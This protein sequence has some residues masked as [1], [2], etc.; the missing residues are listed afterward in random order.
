M[1]SF[2]KLC[3]IVF[4]IY[5]LLDIDPYIIVRKNKA[6]CVCTIEWV[7]MY[8]EVDTINYIIIEDFQ[9]KIATSM[10]KS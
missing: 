8:Y 5:Y 4:T 1:V 9:V 3:H 2:R 10:W 6:Q 7:L